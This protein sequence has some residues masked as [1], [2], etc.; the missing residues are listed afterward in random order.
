[1]IR[2]HQ[3]IFD[4]LNWGNKLNVATLLSTLYQLIIHRYNK[5]IGQQVIVITYAAQI[6]IQHNLLANHKNTKLSRTIVGGL[7]QLL[8]EYS[9]T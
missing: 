9:S 6:L 3:L 4:K 2:H 5:S 1:M 8:A 7:K